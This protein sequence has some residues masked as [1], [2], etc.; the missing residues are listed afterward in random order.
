MTLQGQDNDKGK[1]TTRA[2]ARQRQRQG[3]GQHNDN[4]KGNTS[5]KVNYPTLA[6]GRLGWGTLKFRGGTGR[7]EED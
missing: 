5:R 2:R 6:K 4:D 7:F 3:Q 1:T